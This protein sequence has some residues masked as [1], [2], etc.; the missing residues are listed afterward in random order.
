MKNICKKASAG[1][2]SAFFLLPLLAGCAT[3]TSAPTAAP[4]TLTIYGLDSSDAITNFITSYKKRQPNV[5]VKYKKFDSQDDYESQLIDEMAEGAGPDIF[6]VHNT[7]LPKHLKKLVPLT[8]T[9]LT[10]EAFGTVY[11]NIAQNDFVQP[12][13]VDGT[14]KIYALPLYVDTLALYYNKYMYEKA[15]PERGKPPVTW[16]EIRKESPLLVV[17]KPSGNLLETGS[18]ALGRSDTVARASD[19]LQNFIVQ[20]T[21]FY[22]DALKQAKFAEG[23]QKYFEFM[24]AFSDRNAKEFG[25]GTEL[26]NPNLTGVTP[27]VDALV[28]GKVAA[29]IDYASL[30]RSLNSE[31]QQAKSRGSTTVSNDAIKIAPLPQISAD[32]T[33]HRTLASYYGMGVSRTSKNPALAWDFVQFASSKELSKAYI[34]KVRMPAARRDLLD[35]QKSNPSLSVFI[36]QIGS[37]VTVRSYSDKR[38]NEIFSTAIEQASKGVSART[39]LSAA[40]AAINAILKK[41]APSGMYPKIVAPKKK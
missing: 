1:I 24:L 30:Y 19:I 18:I 21:S 6:Y 39:A 26:T 13:P 7:W 9:S 10:P 28:T 36:N 35:G 12:D 34:D 40:Q 37:A 15:V 2:I 22:D 29:I 14:K 27:E 4:T 41:E 32:V 17:K 8:S 20:S 11:V 3:K 38:Y 33:R 16:D 5:T 31:L 25:W 23:A